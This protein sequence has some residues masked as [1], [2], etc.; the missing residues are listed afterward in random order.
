MDTIIAARTY[1]AKGWSPVPVPRGRKA[2]IVDG[3][4]GLRIREQEIT[5][6]FRV[7]ENVGLLTGEASGGLIDVDLDCDE[8][9][10]L[11]GSFLPATPMWSGRPSRPRSHAWFRASDQV[12]TNATYK[13]INGAVLV[14]LRG[15]GRQTIVAPSL[16]PDDELYQWEGSLEPAD[17]A[18]A[19]LSW[20][21]RRLAVASLL[22][23]RWPRQS[24]SRHDVAR[25]C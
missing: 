17:V 16:H 19:P 11:A 15:T 20:A 2:P 9:V 7:E 6:Y 3:W 12:P 23:R 22:V 10:Q 25:S 24:G 8:A 1:I 4:P 14:E 18:G 13:D 21:V 5:R